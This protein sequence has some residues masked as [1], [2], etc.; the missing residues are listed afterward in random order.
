MASRSPARATPCSAPP[1]VD[2]KVLP[3]SFPFQEMLQG[4]KELNRGEIVE[5]VKSLAS[6]EQVN[7]LQKILYNDISMQ[8]ALRGNQMAWV[9]EFP[10]GLYEEVKLTLSAQCA[11]KNGWTTYFPK[12]LNAKLW[13]PEERMQ[14][15]NAA[16]ARFD[17][18][19]KNGSR[20]EI[21]SSLI[22]IS[23]GGG[24]Q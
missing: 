13:D 17:V 20:S 6:H 5:S 19:L 7:I 9:E 22:R 10:S 3:F 23:G 16:A 21:E 24:V 11:A 14:F 2:S 15:V 8:T 18:L 4:F 1:E 12:R